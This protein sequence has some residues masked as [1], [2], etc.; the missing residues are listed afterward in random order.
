M[1][2]TPDKIDYT[3]A[4]AMQEFNVPGMAVGI[5]KDAKLWLLRRP[6]SRRSRWMHT[7]VT[8][9]MLGAVMQL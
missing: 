7:R 8:T 9:T 2:I 3:V 5:V 1:P 6:V 4:R